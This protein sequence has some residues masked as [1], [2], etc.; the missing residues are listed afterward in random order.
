MAEYKRDKRIFRAFHSTDDDAI[1]ILMD[2]YD[3]AYPEMPPEKRVE[4]QT[5]A[6]EAIDGAQTTNSW[7][8]ISPEGQIQLVPAMAMIHAF[9]D[10]DTDVWYDVQAERVQQ[11]EAHGYTPEHDDE[12]GGDH[13]LE[14]A[15]SYLSHFGETP[16][17]L[18]VRHE[19]IKSI[20]TLVALVEFID[21]SE[22]SALVAKLETEEAIEDIEQAVQDEQS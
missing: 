1:D 12:H 15:K 13:L 18:H 6:Q 9:E 4:V 3:R 16:T 14:V 2:L 21:R 11:I 8:L 5:Q 17:A 7:F 20:A 22:A 19:V 10:A